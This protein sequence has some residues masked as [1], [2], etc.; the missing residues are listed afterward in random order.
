MSKTT[1]LHVKPST[2]MAAAYLC[3]CVK[4]GAC[5][6]WTLLFGRLHHPM[7]KKLLSNPP[8]PELA[9]LIERDPRIVEELAMAHYRL[10]RGNTN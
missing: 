7:W 8:C 1:L 2:L 6:G 5:D 4:H 10:S 3:M 9:E